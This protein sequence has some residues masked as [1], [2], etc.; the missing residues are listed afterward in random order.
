MTPKQD[1]KIAGEA[2]TRDLYRE[3]PNKTLAYTV[4]RPGGLNDK[5]SIGS[6]KVH[7][8]QGDVFSS[9]VTREDVA[10][11]TVAALLGGKKTDFVTFEVNQ[12]EGIGKAQGNLPSPDPRL[13]HAGA[14]SFDALLDGLLTDEAIKNYYPDLISDFRGNDVEPVTK[15]I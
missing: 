12:V 2:I 9:E 4:I 3:S 15:F 10:L 13:V 6:D 14:K 5:P 7:V 8:S 11:V 1:Y